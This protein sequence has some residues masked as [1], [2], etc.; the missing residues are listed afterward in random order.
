[1]TWS[2]PRDAFTPFEDFPSPVAAS[3]HQLLHVFLR[4]HFVRRR[5]TVHQ[6]RCPLVVDHLGIRLLPRR[7]VT[8]DASGCFSRDRSTPGPC[9]TDES[10]APAHRCRCACARSSLGLSSTSR[11]VSFPRCP[12]LL[13]FPPVLS[14]L[15]SSLSTRLIPLSVTPCCKQ[16]GVHRGSVR[17]PDEATLLSGVPPRGVLCRGGLRLPS[18]CS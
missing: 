13:P 8:D 4:R 10:V 11:P 15:R 2:E 3:C 5:R 17:G 9:S 14:H 6:D 1:V 18:C 16:P 7:P 12:C